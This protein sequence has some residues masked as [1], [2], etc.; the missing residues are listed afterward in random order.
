MEFSAF[1]PVIL[2]RCKSRE[3]SLWIWLI[4]CQDLNSFLLIAHWVT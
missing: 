2:M 3:T 4:N 1:L